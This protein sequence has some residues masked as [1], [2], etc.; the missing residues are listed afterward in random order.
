[1]IALT[2]DAMS[3]DRERFMAM[4]MSGYVSKPIEQNELLGEIGRVLGASIPG[5]SSASEPV[6]TGGDENVDD[7]LSDLDRIAQS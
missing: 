5:F 1:M 3:G 2:A 4:G 6:E 7:V